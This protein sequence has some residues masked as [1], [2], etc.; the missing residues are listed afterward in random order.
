MFRS[1]M[2]HRSGEGTRASARLV[3]VFENVEHAAI[4]RD[5][6]GRLVAGG[7]LVDFEQFAD[8]GGAAAQLDRASVDCL[9]VDSSLL[10]GG[11]AELLESML[12]RRPSLAL[13]VVGE[14]PERS[15]LRSALAVGARVS[16]AEWGDLDASLRSAL[17]PKLIRAA[18][19][20][21]FSSPSRSRESEIS[22][23]LRGSV[24]WAVCVVL[25]G[26]A[27]AADN[28]TVTAVEGVLLAGL[29]FATCAAVFRVRAA[30]R[31][32]ALATA[33]ARARADAAFEQALV[34]MCL[35][36]PDGRLI[37]VNDAFCVLVG[38][39]RAGLERIDWSELTH[40]DDIEASR[41][42]V[43]AMLA[44]RVPGF[45]IE[46]RYLRPDG[47][48]VWT[49]LSTHL[50]RDAHGVPAYFSTQVIDLSLR[51]QAE[52]RLAES[53]QRAR[54]ILSSLEE[55]VIMLDAAGTIVELNASAARILA[56]GDDGLRSAWS[57]D[58]YGVVLVDGQDAPL[59]H[60]ELPAVRTLR[61]GQAE[62]GALFRAR[63][64]D[65]SISVCSVNTRP[66]IRPHEQAPYA[67]VASFTDVTERLAA[68]RALRDSETHHRLVL[69]NLPGAIITVYDR[70]MRCLLVEGAYLH[71]R[72]I[73]PS[74]LVGKT[75][76]EI[77]D[78]ASLEA[79]RA[80]MLDAVEGSASTVEY[81]SQERGRDLIVEVAP[82][83]D[84]AGLITGVIN[85]SR[86][87]TER[88][89]A[90]QARIAAE[91]RFEVAFDRAPIGMCL[92]GIDGSFLRANDAL[93]QITGYSDDELGA[94]APFSFVHEDDAASVAER[95]GS[96]GGESDDIS[97]EHRIRQ[98]G[99]AIVWVHASATLVR[100]QAGEPVHV[101]A[102]VQDITERRRYEERLRH[103]ADHDLLT[104]LVNRRGF[105]KAL[106]Q[107]LAR[108]RRYGPKGALMVLDLDGF[109][110]V[111]DSL[112]HHIGDQLIVSVAGALRSRL[113]D[114]DVLARLG[115]DEFAVLL[116][117]EQQP[118]AAI[119]AQALAEIV[120]DS[121]AAFGGLPTGVTASIGVVMFDDASLTADE[122]IINAD[123]AMYDAK[124]AGRNRHSFFSADDHGVPRLTARM[125][126]VKRIRKALDEDRFV[127]HAQPIFELERNEIAWEEVLVRMLA[128]DGE[129]IPPAAF[130]STAERFGLITPI[131]SWV[132]TRAIEAI[133]S[134]AAAGRRLR[135]SVNVS[136]VSLADP[137][138]VDLIK[139][140]LISH[141]ADPANLMLEISE[142]AAV[143]DIPAAQRFARSLQEL[144]CKIALDDFGAGFGSFYYLKHL[145]FDLLKIDGEFVKGATHH[146]SDRLIIQSVA[147]I[148]RGL[149]KQT[150]AEF[151][152]DDHSLRLLARQ[153]VDLA[154]GFHL[155]QPRPLASLLGGAPLTIVE[156]LAS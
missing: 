78:P 26:V 71:E 77:S 104:G 63:H 20:G 75:L 127:L 31:T 15:S 69:R 18:T 131:D 133:G 30:E 3:L 128:D 136:G 62:T 121:A 95:F 81:R 139:R 91:Q 93:T 115:G 7:W 22:G 60:A 97:V 42:G 148:A 114:T 149:G 155:A 101:L 36:A 66:L 14:E 72:G 82:Y 73:E 147:D 153:G 64:P 99:G 57:R 19:D 38:R 53:E 122:V 47:T 61:T 130:L 134:E 12:R 74:V 35:T 89:L 44:G 68:E 83:R 67:V 32:R 96:L 17:G 65:G 118:D 98:A 11:G 154:Q 117:A 43:A 21:A 123:L 112:G 34:G 86:D 79:L 4:F 13:V 111:N 10:A 109:K 54:S 16:F 5:A 113:R 92:V 152:P 56:L 119:V 59:D 84:G 50:V 90:E 33:S 120:R 103:I 125:S 46:K 150:I 102:Q 141:H 39:S 28:G 124:E 145:P 126:W 156:D 24:A 108:G 129:L 58:D 55:G 1:E 138:F 37:E 70:A 48:V 140:L 144:G 76:D 49:S 132:I 143:A 40:P 23:I 2:L 25:V 88:K 9:V 80:A 110:Y 105:E 87:V 51:R 52:S 8:L 137:R 135:L 100:D 29:G 94:I 27:F 85:I 41:E 106:E 116:P 45:Q 6:L 151:V 107:H 146:L 142:T